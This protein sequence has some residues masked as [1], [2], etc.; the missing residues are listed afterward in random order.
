[1]VVE[2]DVVEEDI[3]KVV[4]IISEL[5]VVMIVLE[6]VDVNGTVLEERI[7]DVNNGVV[8]VVV[9]GG[10]TTAT[11]RVIDKL[12]GYKLGYLLSA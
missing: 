4:L 9:G 8:V 12:S 7:D 6:N 3:S 10:G 5:T 1:M 2:E 11:V